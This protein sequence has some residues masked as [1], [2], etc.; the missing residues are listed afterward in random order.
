MADIQFEEDQ[1][2]RPTQT[3]Q[4]PSFITGLVLKLG[5]AKDEKNATV[6]LGIFAAGLIILAILI[7]FVNSPSTHTTTQEQ[8]MKDAQKP[9]HLP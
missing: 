5:L 1:N 9:Q 2:M 7:W 4:K 8:L 6:V 3:E